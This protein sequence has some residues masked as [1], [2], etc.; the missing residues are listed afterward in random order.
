MSLEVANVSASYGAVR[1]LWDVSISVSQGQFVCLVGANGAGKS[2]L[3]K[4][5][6]GMIPPRSG[7]IRF[8]GRGISNLRTH[9]IIRMGIGFV[10]E[11]RR[12]FPTLSVEE[13]LRMGAPR[14]INNLEDSLKKVYTLFPVLEEKRKQKAIALSGGE[15]QMVAIG[16]ALMGSPK[17]L[18]LDELSF[19]LAPII[20]DRVLSTIL[21]IKQ[22][23]VSVLM[24]EQNAER[25]LEV[26]DYSYVMENGRVVKHG[27]STDLIDDPLVK[28]AYLGMDE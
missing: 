10:P 21:Q 7:T 5:I 4:T 15:Q 11:G 17:L 28:E 23:G 6:V 27:K 16:R 25:A 22:A 8:N 9:S 24:A 19:G 2:T 18:I 12:L 13:N 14:A 3:L 1:A 26:S 20:F